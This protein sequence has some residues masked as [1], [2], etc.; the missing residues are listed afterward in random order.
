MS[1]QYI[2]SCTISEQ[3][4]ISCLLNKPELIDL[5]T[6]NYCSNQVSK[7][8]F[9]SLKVLYNQEVSFNI[10]TVVAHVLKINKDITNEIIETLKEKV[11]ID[12]KD[13]EHYKKRII[14]A[15]VKEKVQTKFIKE[16]TANLI[17]KGE[18]NVNTLQQGIDNL[19]WAIDTVKQKNTTIK[20]MPEL[21]ER[22]EF[23]LLNRQNESNAISTGN[24]YLDSHLYCQGI[25][26]GQFGTIFG[27]S[28]VGKSILAQN[29][30][31]G[32][33]NKQI[34]TLY[35]P[36]E[37]GEFPTM[38]RWI[39]SRLGI[40]ISLFSEIDHSTGKISDAVIE[41]FKE[42]KKRLQRIKYFHLVD[43]AG[44]NISNIKDLI[45]DVKKLNGKQDLMVVIDLF[46]MLNDF[47]GEAK[48]NVYSDA[49]DNYFDLIKSENVASLV[50]VQAR[51]TEKIVVSCV[52]DC[53][54]FRPTTEMIKNSGSLEERSRT[55][56]G[57][58]RKKHY[59]NKYIPDD[60]EGL[61]T[62]DIMEV[63]ILKNN[64][65]GLAHLKYLYDYETSKIWKY[66]E[67][68]ND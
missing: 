30:V 49:V 15:Y 20:S 58:F 36:N 54:K 65:G 40:P 28:G 27:L 11:D 14:D 53:E 1:N 23:N 59:I 21:A 63:S 2:K 46:T 22:Y 48:A 3:Q 39:A 51:R 24:S 13:F 41:A 35:V 12:L 25:L 50:V 56:L 62:E 4:Y 67:E 52:D 66:E 55:I 17:S 64:M 18:L 29:C 44:L 42:E 9:D 61:I 37:M 8:I 10:Q 57:V 68:K 16:I 34:P 38:D 7:D 32:L 26:K 6:E 33:I 60:P 45:K 47:K 19:E 31:N 5:E 43:E